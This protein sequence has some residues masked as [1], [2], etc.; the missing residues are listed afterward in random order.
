M[1]LMRR[2]AHWLLRMGIAA[3]FLF[4]GLTKFSTLDAFAAML[5]MPWVVALLVALC[6][7]LGGL[8]VFAGGFFK[9]AWVTR[10]GC[11]LIIPVVCGAAYMMHWGQWS[12]VPSETH[13]MGG[14]EFHTV[15]LGVLFYLLIK[16]REV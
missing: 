5:K 13:P 9:A 10:L 3:V 16:G 8:L 6:E 1:G 4:H 2:Y 14:V 12:F 15:L 7:S 11:L